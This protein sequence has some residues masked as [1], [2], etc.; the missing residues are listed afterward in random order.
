MS[1]PNTL[2]A[3]NPAAGPF[4]L[5]RRWSTV[6]Y[7]AR[8]AVAIFAFAAIALTLPPQIHDM[9]S[10]LADL[11]DM[12][13]DAWSTAIKFHLCMILIALTLWYWS[14]AVLL[15]AHHVP[16]S[17]DGRRRFET[18][19]RAEGRRDQ[20]Q[21]FHFFDYVP[22]GLAFGTAVIAGIATQ[23]SEKTL[24]TVIVLVWAIA[25]HLF[26]THRTQWGLARNQGSM[27][28]RDVAGGGFFHK[29]WQRLLELLDYAPFGRSFAAISLILAAGLFAASAATAFV[30][31]SIDWKTAFAR[32]LPGPSVALFLMGMAVAPLTVLTFEVD[33]SVREI[34]LGFLVIPLRRVPALL[35]LLVLI[36][37]GS[38]LADLHALRVVTGDPTSDPGKRASLAFFL[39]K[40]AARCAPGDGPVQPVIVAVSG[41]AS[42]AGL[43][44]AKVLDTVD[45]SLRRSGNK[46]ASIF[47]ISSV[48]GGSF[49]T[50]AYVSMRG[51]MSAPAGDC[52]LPG[53]GANRPARDDAEVEA[54]SG[55]AIGPALAGT[56]LGDI[57][58][59]LAIYIAKPLASL[60]L[61]AP[62]P[63]DQIHYL[64]GN[65]RAAALEHA[66]ED[67]W[68]NDGIVEIQKLQKQP[69]PLDKGYLWTYYGQGHEPYGDVPLWIA[70]GTDADEGDRIITTPFKLNDEYFC[71]TDGGWYVR[72]PGETIGKKTPCGPAKA[73]FWY[74]M[75][76]FQHARDALGLIKSDIPLSTTIDNTSRFPF[77]SPS[78]SLTPTRPPLPNEKTSHTAHIIDG[79]YF[80]NEGVETAQELAGWL[81]TYGPILLHRPVY[82]IIVQATSDAQ[83]AINEDDIPRC[84][85]RPYNPSVVGPTQRTSQFLVPLVGA[86]VVR[87]GSSQAWLQQALNDYCDT[88]GHQAFFNFYLYDGDGFEVPLNWALDKQVATFIWQTK[89]GSMGRCGNQA[90]LANLDATLKAPAG[91]WT[92]ETGRRRARTIQSCTTGKMKTVPLLPLPIPGSGGTAPT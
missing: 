64:R 71:Q 83:T 36:G 42:R 45:D 40:W 66:F 49:G 15:A 26:F 70:N 84:T 55:D 56:M 9:L 41:G 33:H 53:L 57:P 30:P 18:A 59:A 4:V 60:H 85:N 58:R 7:R 87:T 35:I 12:S 88:G 8:A 76:P 20:I 62:D 69:I 37:I 27:P 28:P 44:A 52:T 86:L 61:M 91:D 16:D 32:F 51:A 10:D 79:G 21:A 89:D 63:D 65:D 38:T 23:R 74:A 14:R 13:A 47:A 1:Q 75:G 77:L 24:Q 3:G 82:P 17:A 92:P 90:E 6:I 43:W 39:Q 11:S 81:R 54:L 34:D 31:D 19:M 29:L 72:K 5:P 80:E 2:G 67:L 73:A 78:G 68:W 46:S 22:R 25:L 48:S 50:A